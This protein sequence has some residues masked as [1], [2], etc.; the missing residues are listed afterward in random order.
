MQSSGILRSVAPK[1]RRSSVRKFLGSR[2][3][4]AHIRGK[5]LAE[6]TDPVEVFPWR[7]FR[8]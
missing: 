4:E 5:A 3:V 2:F 7:P 6:E 8:S 1:K